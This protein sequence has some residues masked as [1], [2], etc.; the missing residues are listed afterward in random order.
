MAAVTPWLTYVVPT[1][2]R[3]TLGRLLDSADDPEVEILLMADTHGDKF[4]ERLDACRTAFAGRVNVRWV[5]YDAGA[6]HWGNPQRQEGMRLATAP[7]IAFS[8]D[9]NELLPGALDIMRRAAQTHDGPLL[10]RVDTWQAGVV[11][12][13]PVLTE[14]N[15]DADCIIVPNDP[16]RLGTWGPEY[17]ADFPFIQETVRLWGNKVTWQPETIARSRFLPRVEAPSDEG[18]LRDDVQVAV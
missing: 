10:F 16:R 15:I 4:K 13:V 11:W 1:I 17:A 6:H 5:D 18:P 9:D 14:R 3:S 2:G 12:K 8:Q 7:Y